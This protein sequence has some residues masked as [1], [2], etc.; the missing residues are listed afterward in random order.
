TVA[1][2]AASVN[3]VLAGLTYTATAEFEGSDTLNVTVTSKDGSNTSATQGTASTA[4]TINPVAEAGTAA[5]PA[6]LTLN[7]NA[8]NVAISGVSVGPLAEDGDDTVSAVLAVGHGTLSV[9]S[10]AGV[11]VT[12][13]GTS[14]VTV[15]G[16]AASVNAVLAGLTYTPAAEY[17]GSDTLSVTVT[18]SDGSNTSATQGTASTAITV[19]PV[20]EAGSAVA[21]ATLSLSENAAGVAIAGVSVGP[22]AED[23]DDT[24]STVLSVAH[25]TLHVG[26]LA[27]V[28]IGGDDSATLTVAGSAA[29]V[30]TVLA[31]LTYTPTTE[32]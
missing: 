13:N 25:G 6:T 31:G 32:Y 28:T 19:N 12:N 9:G 1:G 18:S 29:S 5:A 22:L 27:G 26:S 11:T 7:E 24:V 2:S 21:P 23:G 16:S 15:A 3:T 10:L 4:I 14:S 17:E 20:A 30:N 8:T